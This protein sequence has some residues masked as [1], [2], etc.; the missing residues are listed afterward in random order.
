MIRLRSTEYLSHSALGGPYRHNWLAQLAPGL[1]GINRQNQS[2]A[3]TDLLTR[4]AACL[5]SQALVH[6]G[7][8]PAVYTPAGLAPRRSRPRWLGW[9]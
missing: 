4:P 5:P 3:E 9:L 2:E 8:N 7:Q 1:C 6:R